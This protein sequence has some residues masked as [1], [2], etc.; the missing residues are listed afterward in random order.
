MVRVQFCHCGNCEA[1]PCAF[2]WFAGLVGA[3]SS[4]YGV[5]EGNV[6]YLTAAAGYIGFV[7]AAAIGVVA[8][9]GALENKPSYLVP[10]V[11]G[12]VVLGVAMHLLFPFRPDEL[13][14][15]EGPNALSIMGLVVIGATFFVGVS[16]YQDWQEAQR[17]PTKVCPDCANVV[18]AAAR[19]CQHCTYK[20]DPAP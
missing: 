12:S 2:K 13:E 9:S 10:T 1:T 18:L 17:P 3:V 11:I 5:L 6:W 16:L 19:V 20:F 7:A 4:V 8:A 14:G 15:M